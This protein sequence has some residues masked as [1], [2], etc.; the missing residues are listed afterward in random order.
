[1]L[2]YELFGKMRFSFFSPFSFFDLPRFDK[3]VRG[4]QNLK[5]NTKWFI[6]ISLSSME[7]QTFS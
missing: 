4:G 7:R 3:S 6:V 5:E 2:V 1:M